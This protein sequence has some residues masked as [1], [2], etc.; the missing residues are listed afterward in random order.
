MPSVRRVVSIVCLSLAAVIAAPSLFAPEPHVDA[1]PSAPSIVGGMRSPAFLSPVTPE[2]IARPTASPSVVPQPVAALH[3]PPAAPATRVDYD[4]VAVHA[5]IESY[6]VQDGKLT[7]PGKLSDKERIFALSYS[8]QAGEGTNN[9][10]F[11]IGH[12]YDDGS[13]VF[14]RI[15]ALARADQLIVVTTELGKVCYDVDHI[16]KEAKA[17]FDIGKAAA[18][19]PHPGWLVIISCYAA[20][21]DPTTVWGPD[22]SVLYAQ[23]TTCAA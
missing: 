4:A 13:G 22:V 3:T 9:S 11:L 20:P 15:M 8:L 2:Q 21:G 7:P 1:T 23:T 12:S 18:Q 10:F 5:K 17:D 16:S 14:N 6:V 19:V